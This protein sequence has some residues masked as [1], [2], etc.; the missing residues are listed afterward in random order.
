ML[1]NTL[2]VHKKVKKRALLAFLQEPVRRALNGEEMYPFSNLGLAVEIVRQ[3]NIAGYSVD[4][5][6]WN[7]VNVPNGKT[8]DLF[9]GHGSV[10]F[11]KVLKLNDIKKVIY[12]ATGSS[13]KFHNTEASKRAKYFAQRHGVKYAAD[14]PV[15]PIEQKVYTLADR[16]VCLGNEHVRNTFPN[17]K[18]VTALHI[19]VTKE[20][21]ILVPNLLRSKRH[22]LFFSG[23]GNLHKGLDLAIDAVIGTDIVLHVCTS[24]D[25][26]FRSIF[27]NKYGATLNRNVVWHG[28]ISQRSLKFRSL[29][30]KCQ[31]AILLSCSEGSPGSLIDVMQYGLIPIITPACGLDIKDVGYLVEDIG[32]DNIRT[33][34]REITSIDSRTLRSQSTAVMC[35]VER[36][37]SL[38]SFQKKLHTVLENIA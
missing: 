32:V 8:Y 23:G 2:L 13:A 21:K 12:F 27:E 17:P 35:L 22:L 1:S 4:V 30:R 16:V 10:N 20:R 5:I 38:A 7:D 33:K 37:Y 28:F 6:E 26:E 11:E 29:I 36:E 34:L 31:F 24:I 15:S 25:P 9:V 18:K 3:L 14:R 19:A